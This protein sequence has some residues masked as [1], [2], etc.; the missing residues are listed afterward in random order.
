MLLAEFTLRWKEGDRSCLEDY[1]SRLGAWPLA[2]RVELI[3]RDYCLAEQAGSCACPEE[4]LRR[5]PNEREALARLFG[6][7]QVLD[8]SLLSLWSG[9]S[10]SLDRLP[11][12]GDEVGPYLL[13]RELGRGGFAR[14]FLAEQG[15]LD[16]RLVVVKLS[17]RVTREPSLL[18][19]ASHPHIVEIL[20]H[21]MV[22][23]GM[24]Q[25]ICMPFLGGA[26]LAAVLAERR[27]RGSRGRGRRD[28]SQ[29]LLED[30]DRVSAKG[31]LP[32]ST[33]RP[34]REVIARLSYPRAT[35][36]II[37]RLAEALDHAFGR[38]VVHGDLKPSNILLAADGTPMLL[39]FNLAVGWRPEATGRGTGELPDEVGGTLAYM[40]PERLR[41]VAEPLQAPRLSLPD[42]HRADVFSLGLV[43]LEM[44]TG[45]PPDLPGGQTQSL[46]QQAS[47]YVSVRR[48]GGEVIIRSTRT[49]LPAGLRAILARCLAP[50]PADRYGRARELAEDLDRWRTDRALAHAREPMLSNSLTRWARRRR[51]ALSAALTG[52]LIAIS[53]TAAI[54]WLSTHVWHPGSSR[55]PYSKLVPDKSSNDLM[56]LRPGTSLVMPRANPI[57]IARGHLEH[58]GVIGSGDWRRRGKF[59]S[60]SPDEQ[61]EIEAWLIEQALR[62]AHA[63]DQRFEAPEDWRRALLCVERVAD[64]STPFDPLQQIR[65]RLRSR[66]RLPDPPPVDLRSN[67]KVIGGWAHDYLHGV[68]SELEHNLPDAAEHYEAALQARPGSFWTNYRAAVVAF[69]LGNLAS[70]QRTEAIQ[71]SKDQ[72]VPLT[73]EELSKAD[74]IAHRH[75][76]YAA[77]RLEWCVRLCPESAV[78]RDQLAGCLRGQGLN[79]EAA[80]QCNAAEILDPYHAETFLSRAMLRLDLG[81]IDSFLKDIQRYDA[82]KYGRDSTVSALSPLDLARQPDVIATAEPPSRRRVD[83]GPDDNELGHFLARQLSHSGRPD[84]ALAEIDRVL[85]LDP[86]DIQA[87][88]VRGMLRSH[89]GRT[90]EAEKDFARVVAHPQVEKFVM[91]YS[92][93]LHS[94]DQHLSALIRQRRVDEALETARRAAKLASLVNLDYLRAESQYNLARAFALASKTDPSLRMQVAHHLAEAAGI[95]PAY[96]RQRGWK[97]PVFETMRELIPRTSAPHSFSKKH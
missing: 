93:A 29:N 25:V 7:H 61:S 40:A 27:N 36:W 96:V 46:S 66:L 57:E 76:A 41:T 60:L 62:F 65:R 31:Y 6:V 59:S 16:D 64:S 72:T 67:A 91:S 70:T 68:A 34:A 3:Y 43:M 63:L 73:Y 23:G 22:D 20:W 14:V 37:A 80:E 45:R 52:L 8:S 13:V 24:L 90:N 79:R 33:G 11:E 55:S 35:A 39:D 88:Y 87:L 47:A 92:R 21:G 85:E 5:F 53:T 9:P 78:L 17:T 81:Q 38:G 15:D 82:L 12:V 74:A 30:L 4:Y 58:F 48:Q 50:H 56:Y 97:E 51:T 28:Q 86:D 10:G 89:A 77:R 84:L 19:R 18:A 1:L 95:D 49:T 44:L 32:L 83:P 71:R 94:F 2:H 42:R 75:F 26:T 54:W 69:A